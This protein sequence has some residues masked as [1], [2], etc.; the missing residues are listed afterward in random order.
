M[1]IIFL[2]LVLKSCTFTEVMILIAL[3]GFCRSFMQLTVALCFA[4]YLPPERF[5]SGYGLFLFIQGNLSFLLSPFT[6]WVRD[7]TQSYA[8]C[9]HSL[10]VL[11]CV[12]LIPW[13]IEMIGFQNFSRKNKK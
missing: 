13:T 9:Y 3:T 1:T 6:G 7:V 12:C 8:I 4:E 5:P 11:M 10:T 2:V